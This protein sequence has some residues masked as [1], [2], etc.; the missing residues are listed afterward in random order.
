MTLTT[1][2]AIR[3]AVRYAL[4]SGVATAVAM[5]VYAQDGDNLAEVIVTGSRI[6]RDEYT[7]S[8]PIATFDETELKASGKVSVDEFLMNVPA[9]TGYQQTTATNNGSDG[10]KKVDLRGLG[11]NRSLVLINGR[12][13]IGDVN[14]DGAVDLNTIPTALIE[15][16][17]VLKDGASTVYGSDA[18]AGVI[19]V[20]LKRDF[21]GLEFHA[22]YGAGMEDGQAENKSVSIVGGVSGDRGNIVL[23][24]TYSTQS[25]MVQAERD[26][27]L[28]D[29]YPQLDDA[30]NFVPVPSGSSTSRRIRVPGLSTFRI[31]DAETGRA[32]PFTPADTYNFAPVNALITPNDTWQVSVLGNIDIAEGTRGYFEG[33]YTRRTSHQRLAADASFD[34]T[35]NI[36]TQ[37][38]GNQWNNW[39][40]ASNPYNPYGVNPRNDDGLSNLDVRVNRRF[41]ESGGRLFVQGADTFRMVAGVEG[42][43]FNSG[44]NYD[45]SYTFAQNEVIDDTR[46]Y[47]RF[48]RW[49]IAVDPDA[50]A[51]DPACA[52]VGVLNPFDD[53][54]SITPGQMAYL[55]TGSLKDRYFGQLHM[56]ALGLSGDTAALFSL[57]GGPIGWAVGYEQRAEKGEFS[58][59]EFVAGGLTT[60][61]A[62]DPQSGSF[63][64]KEAYAELLLPVLD[65]LNFELSARHSDYDTSAGS[66]TTYRFGV[67]YAPIDSL[68]VRAGY[69]TGFRA[70]NI[71]ELNQGDTGSFPI[72]ETVC[73]YA[74]RKLAAGDLTQV[75]YDNCIA[76]GADPTDDGALGFAWQSLETTSA[77]AVPLKPEESK[78]FTAGVVF[79]PSFVSGLSLSLD[80]WKIEIDDVIGSPDFNDLVSVCINSVGMS[81]P[82]CGVFD[83]DGDGIP[84]GVGVGQPYFQD[85]GVPA[86]VVIE[87]GNLGKLKTAGIDFNASY[88]MDVDWGVVNRLNFGWAATYV[89]TFKRSYA[90]TG[91]KELV[92]TAN[93]FAVYPEWRWNAE[94]GVSGNDWRVAWQTRFIGETNDL[95]R[96]A[97]ATDDAVVEEMF[98]HDIVASY[99]WNNISFYG[100][101]NNVFDEDPPFFHSAFNAETEPGM[102]DVIGRRFYLGTKISF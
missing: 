8:S 82:A 30:G 73:E 53:Y 87:F 75:A 92:G 79:T 63:R 96:P 67:D 4:F 34:V 25:E 85:E 12:R 100:G 72:V 28:Y 18:L 7:S 6:K 50:C 45:V 52:A 59:D 86:D 102:Y 91:D 58:P 21:N 24:L 2:N 51:A 76:M 81:H 14:G 49:V 46:N 62:G 60:G 13:Q 33:L 71:S 95:L 43:I 77:P 42:E 23:G 38:Y 15:R 80:Y 32:R 61:G 78:S 70:P 11:F 66:K 10:Q 90:L 27:A 37:G 47:G 36:P 41:V 83:T 17:E 19:N 35:S 74:D 31:V 57:P 16:V 64:V 9:F 29:L 54:G 55:S 26:W 93:G 88:V 3:R 98:Y 94:I 48:D 56:A 22:D 89:D 99:T 65:N 101:I 20:I 97:S 1:R 68:R 84:D 44:I 39:V 5:P 69:A 40:P